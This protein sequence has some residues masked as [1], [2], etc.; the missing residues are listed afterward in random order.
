[1]EVTRRAA[2]WW[3]EMFILRAWIISPH[4]SNN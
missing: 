3:W 2:A 4:V 1:M